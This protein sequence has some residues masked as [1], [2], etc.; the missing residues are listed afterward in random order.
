MLPG[1]DIHHPHKTGDIV[2]E[3]IEK[4]TVLPE[5]KHIIRSIHRHGLVSDKQQDA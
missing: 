1:S 2:P 5:G 4:G 3:I